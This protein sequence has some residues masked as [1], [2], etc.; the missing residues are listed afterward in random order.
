MTEYEILE[1]TFSIIDSMATGTSDKR[2]S[3]PHAPGGPGM[4]VQDLGSIGEIVGAVAV[5][6]TLGYLSL[7]TRQ[8]RLA[9][10]V[11]AKYAGL[12]ATHSIVNLYV[13]A[14]PTL[15]EHKESIA[16]AN[17]GEE[18]PEAEKIALSIVFHDLLYA[19]LP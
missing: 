5:L 18:L 8:A 10:E 19:P 6:F 7:Q 4:T 2:L 16:K 11:A 12:Q 1:L 14:R 3:L 9:A 13:E 17:A 15:L